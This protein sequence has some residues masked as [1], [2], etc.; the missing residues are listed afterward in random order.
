MTLVMYRVTELMSAIIYKVL[1]VMGLDPSLGSQP[2]PGSYFNLNGPF[3]NQDLPPAC[4]KNANDQR[5]LLLPSNRDAG[6]E[7]E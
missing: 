3:Q 5:L 1:F 7:R 2:L 6:L 4:S